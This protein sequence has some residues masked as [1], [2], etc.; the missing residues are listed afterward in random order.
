LFVADFDVK[1]GTTFET[2]HQALQEAGR[3]LRVWA[4]VG[5]AMNTVA[6]LNDS[7]VGPEPNPT[8]SESDA[9]TAA[10]DSDQDGLAALLKARLGTSV[11]GRSD[12]RTGF[13]QL[14]A[15]VLTKLDLQRGIRFSQVPDAAPDWFVSLFK[16]IDSITQARWARRRS[17]KYT[18]EK[19]NA[20][21][22]ELQLLMEDALNFAGKCPELGLRVISTAG[23]RT[24]IGLDATD[25]AFGACKGT[26][27]DIVLGY[28]KDGCRAVFSVLIELKMHLGKVNSTP[29]SHTHSHA[30]STNPTT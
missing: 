4:E 12:N 5:K 23:G 30:H 2:M 3:S 13:S 25:T 18:P 27:G 8:D 10:E 28:F 29:N 6:N 14:S 9:S 19:A 17:E 11:V 16:L 26:P 7:T 24:F 1:H 22:S 20:L 15:K 21:E